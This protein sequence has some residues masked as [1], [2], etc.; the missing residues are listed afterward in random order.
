MF[1][2]FFSRMAARYI[3]IKLIIATIVILIII[4]NCPMWGCRKRGGTQRTAGGRCGGAASDARRDTTLLTALDW[5]PPETMH[6]QCCVYELWKVAACEEN[7]DTASYNAGS[8][9]AQTEALTGSV[10]TLYHPTRALADALQLCM[11]PSVWFAGP[12]QNRAA[13][14]TV[15]G[16]Y[17][18]WVYLVRVSAHPL[19][20]PSGWR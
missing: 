9:L 1:G 17:C 8:S 20:P 6:T 14:T 12:G 19:A 7:K 4:C 18:L 2:R 10:F 3:N 13:L 15:C 5:H 16:G 11:N